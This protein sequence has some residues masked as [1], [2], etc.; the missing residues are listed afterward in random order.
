MSP[1]LTTS[2]QLTLLTTIVLYRVRKDRHHRTTTEVLV[3]DKKK[4]K[5]LLIE[6]LIMRQWFSKERW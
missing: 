4:T 2:L 5:I 3:R 6:K 1:L